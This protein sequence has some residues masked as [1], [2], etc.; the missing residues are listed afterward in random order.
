MTTRVE[1]QQ[2]RQRFEIFDGD[3]LAGYSDYVEH[4]G[5]RDFNHTVTLPEFRGRGL[6]AKITEFALDDTR[7]AGAKVVPTCWFVRDFIA[8]SDKYTDLLA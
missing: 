2:D 7:D 4:D 8:S 5:V 6:A 3:T 1:H